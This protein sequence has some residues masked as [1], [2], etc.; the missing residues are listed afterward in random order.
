[1]QASKPGITKKVA[2]APKSMKAGVSQPRDS[3]AE[4]FKKLKARAK[5]SGRIADAAAAF[6]RFL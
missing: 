6:E 5:Q 3:Q 2:D 1:L 4:E